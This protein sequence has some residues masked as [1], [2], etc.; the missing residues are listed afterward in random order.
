MFERSRII[1]VVV[2]S[3]GKPFAPL[4]I[5]RITG[6]M[7][8]FPMPAMPLQFGPPSQF[9]LKVKPYLGLILVL[10]SVEA[11]L[12]L[13]LFLDFTGRSSCSW[14]SRWASL[15][16]PGLESSSDRRASHWFAFAFTQMCLYVVPCIPHVFPHAPN[17]CHVLWLSFHFF[18]CRLRRT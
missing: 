4:H 6:T 17:S 7:V 5:C 3:C 13:C 2:G 1:E 18:V 8:L 14:A 12:R 9:A 15:P 16:T 11:V 10:Q